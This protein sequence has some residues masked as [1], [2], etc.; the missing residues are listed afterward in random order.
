MIR[1][2]VRETKVTVD[3]LI[4]PLF[5]VEGNNI[6]KEISSLQ[7]NYHFSIDQLE[8]EIKELVALGIKGVQI[9]RASCRER[10]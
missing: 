9:G 2:L 1:S 6:K 8:D 4:Y 7:G 10:V 5:I 3:D